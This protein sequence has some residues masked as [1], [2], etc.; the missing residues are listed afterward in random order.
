MGVLGVVAV[1]KA[2]CIVFLGV[3][4]VLEE[5]VLEWMRRGDFRSHVEIAGAFFFFSKV[6]VWNY[7]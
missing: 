7:V 5:G 1:G 6:C 2:A 3:G 4:S